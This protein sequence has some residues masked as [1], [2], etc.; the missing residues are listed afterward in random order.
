MLRAAGDVLA[1]MVGYKKKEMT[2]NGQ[3]NWR[4]RILQKQKVLQKELSI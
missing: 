3:P 1:K 2:G 4:R